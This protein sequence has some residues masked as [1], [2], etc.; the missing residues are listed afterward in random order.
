[1]KEIYRQQINELNLL[2]QSK[3]D[4][5]K[6]ISI[7][8]QDIDQIINTLVGKYFKQECN[9]FSWRRW[10][11]IGSSIGTEQVDKLHKVC[12]VLKAD[13]NSVY[14]Q[15]YAECINE[16]TPYNRLTFECS[17]RKVKTSDFLSDYQQCISLEEYLS[18]IKTMQNRDSYSCWHTTL[19]IQQKILKFPY[20]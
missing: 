17:F 7:K 9:P 1:M 6:Q 14:I 11:R 16:V 2:I 10:A 20:L 19:R 18:S 13:V 5:E 3:E 8:I 12:Q 15:E 4:L